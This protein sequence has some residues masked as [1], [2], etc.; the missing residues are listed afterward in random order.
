MKTDSPQNDSRPNILLIMTDQQRGDC[1]G[2]DGHPVLETPYLDELAS[3]GTRFTRAY[4]ACPSCIPA[5]ASLLT[6]MSQWQTGILGMGYGQ[7]PIPSHF[8]HTMPGEL[9]KAGYHT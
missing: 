9:A 8:K 4:T 5:R 6:G 3:R 2:A 7:G 1:L